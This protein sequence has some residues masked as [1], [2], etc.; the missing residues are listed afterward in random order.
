MLTGSLLTIFY[1]GL[2]FTIFNEMPNLI[3]MVVIE[4]M[5]LI[6]MFSTYEDD[7]ESSLTCNFLEC[8]LTCR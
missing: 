2:S 4:K 8:C 1:K 3:K 6:N 5:A 7:Y